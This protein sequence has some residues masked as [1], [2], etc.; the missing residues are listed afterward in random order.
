MDS[1]GRYCFDPQL[2]IVS[3]LESSPR[4]ALPY[5][6]HT[7]FTHTFKLSP[8][9]S[10]LERSRQSG[11]VGVSKAFDLLGEFGKFGAERKISL[12]DPSA[13]AAFGAH[14]GEAVDKALAD[15]VLLQGQ[16][17][18]AM[19]EALLVSLGE[20]H[21]LKAEDGGRI[22]PPE[23]FR[24][25]DF[26]VV[27]MDGAHWLIEVKNVYEV[28]PFGQR[29][30][31]MT[32]EYRKALEAFA[33]ATSAELKLAVF[34][35]RWALWTLVSPARLVEDGGD[36]T[37]DMFTAM[38]VNELGRLGDRSI[39][40][41]PPLR[42][43]LTADPE[44][45]SPIGPD[46]MV[47]ITIGDVRVFCAEKEITDRTEQE[48]AW[49]FMQHGEWEEIEPEAIVQ[50][51]RLHAIE[52]RWEPRERSNQGFE[53]IGSLSRMFARYFADHTLENNAVIQLRAPMRPN[54][55]V[56]LIRADHE[57]HTL[58]LWR[59]VLQPNYEPFA[60]RGES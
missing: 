28:D 59:F 8:P 58:P 30:K 47:H 23:E 16:R 5:L 31:L 36:L 3:S 40:T 52:F 10:M 41:R 4:A 19:F 48:I 43:R 32:R 24:V 33:A 38:K 49:I 37:L 25:P 53:F 57:S 13:R 9:D 6:I 15:P 51:D 14:V 18:E 17:V 22:F 29:R 35:A 7:D 50:G 12:R 42:L 60:V 27:L 55:F 54:W 44:H 45:T 34:W 11:A 56:P 21:L 1:I 39:G 2:Q 46:G 20:Y 26:R